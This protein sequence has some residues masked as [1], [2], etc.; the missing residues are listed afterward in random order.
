[1]TPKTGERPTKFR[2]E[3]RKRFLSPGRG[4]TTPA[5]ALAE[6]A[7]KYDG[8]PRKPLNGVKESRRELERRLNW[9]RNK[10]AV[11]A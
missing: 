1:M 11:A 7:Q 3:R 2:N 5:Q 6:A 9:L 8:A 10:A 4:D